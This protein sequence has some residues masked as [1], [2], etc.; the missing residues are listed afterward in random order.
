M[1]NRRHK[2]LKF[3]IIIMISINVVSCARNKK[4]DKY[5]NIYDA[6]FYEVYKKDRMC[7]QLSKFSTTEQT[8]YD[9]VELKF[10]SRPCDATSLTT[11]KLDMTTTLFFL[12]HTNREYREVGDLFLDLINDQ[13]LE[14]EQYKKEHGN[15]H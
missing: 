7:V 11:L 15:P 9:I 6:F 5:T 1:M 3:F 4:N 14:Y 10:L 8:K 2:K 12:T 13:F